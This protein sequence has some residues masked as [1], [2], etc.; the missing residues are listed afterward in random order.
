MLGPAFQLE[1]DAI[2]RGGSETGNWDISVPEPR[3]SGPPH[4]CYVYPGGGQGQASRFLGFVRKSKENHHG[5]L[6]DTAWWPSRGPQRRQVQHSGACQASHGVMHGFA[7]PSGRVGT[8][9]QH[10][11]NP[12][13][14]RRGPTSETIGFT[15]NSTALDNHMRIDDDPLPQG[16]R[17]DDRF[18]KSLKN[19]WIFMTF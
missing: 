13:G 8:I 18:R 4:Q 9:H 5:G 7:L 19:Q 17:G 2:C 6:S 16:G 1:A 10:I 15:M 11:H 3:V 14:G 12:Q